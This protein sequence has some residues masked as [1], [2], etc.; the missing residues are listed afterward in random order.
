MDRAERIQLWISYFIR[1]NL[2]IALVV[3]VVTGQWLNLFLIV[4]IF[5]L[6]FLPALLERNYKV[7]LPIEFEFAIIVFVY[8]SLYLGD[9][10]SFYSRFWWWDIFLHAGSGLILGFIGFLIVY[11]LNTEQKIRLHMAPKFAALFSFTFSIALGAMWE[12]IEFV[13][14]VI[15]GSNMQKSGLQDTMLDLMLDTAGALVVSIF[16]YLYLKRGK[17]FLFDTIL[18]NFIEENPKLFAGHKFLLG[19]KLKEKWKERKKL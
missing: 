5:A 19:K 14:D 4:I 13:L 18:R 11:I 6:T 16:G 7:S 17:A 9:Y 8:L 2:L 12:M 3:A 1:I 15:L 10:H